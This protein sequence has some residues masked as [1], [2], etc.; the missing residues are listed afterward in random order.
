MTVLIPNADEAERGRL[1]G[2]GEQVHLTWAPEHI[3]LVKEAGTAA[4]AENSEQPKTE[5][6]EEAAP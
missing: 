6:A 2:G 3:H 5:Q 4:K 1:P